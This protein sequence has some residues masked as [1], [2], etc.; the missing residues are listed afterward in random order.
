MEFRDAIRGA[1]ASVCR[2]Q[3]FEGQCAESKLKPAIAEALEKLGFEVDIEDRKKFLKAGMYVWRE[4]VEQKKW[5]DWR[6]VPTAARR[7][8]DL[9]V[10]QRGTAAALIETESD[11]NDLVNSGVK[12]R[13]GHY[14]V[15]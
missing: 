15:A 4:K 11:L 8:I 12:R 10:Y 1:I 3:A 7:K 6:V 14:D 9:V 2:R 5:I 13:N